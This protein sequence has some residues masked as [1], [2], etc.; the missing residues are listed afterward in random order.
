M[1]DFKIMVSEEIKLPVHLDIVRD[2]YYIRIDI[3]SKGRN[4]FYIAKLPCP[5]LI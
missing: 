4:L 3:D 2:G 1:L 5:T